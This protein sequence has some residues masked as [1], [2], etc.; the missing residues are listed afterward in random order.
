M[1][2]AWLI[3]SLD[4]GGSVDPAA[5][6]V[7][8]VSKPDRLIKA[9]VLHLA[10]K[11]PVVTPVMH[12]DFV[13]GAMLA[14]FEKYG[15]R[16]PTRYVVDVSN[17]S[18]IAYMMANALPKQSL[19]GVKITGGEGHAA[20]LVPMLVG[21]VGGR[22]SSIPIMNL[23]RRQ[24]LLDIGSAFQSGQLSLPLDDPKQAK[25]VQTLK[26]QMNR[27][28]LKQTPSGKQIAVVN[29]GHDDLLLAVAQAWASTRL[30]P[31]RDP[32]TLNRAAHA[33][34]PVDA[35]YPWH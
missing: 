30:P 28:S 23:S 9:R 34:G 4:V 21:D 3:C 2:V 32:A 29:R 19:I 6:T 10:I 13:Q 11:N 15:P 27:A 14:I 12:I 17:N 24:L 33:A 8:H 5:L 25:G 31:P 7:L 16:I 20:G 22:A 26:E 35:G 1:S 18:A